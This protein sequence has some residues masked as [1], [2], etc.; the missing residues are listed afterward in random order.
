METTKKN[1]NIPG[2]KIQK[3]RGTGSVS[4]LYA[5]LPDWAQTVARD[6]MQIDIEGM[7]LVLRDSNT[8]SKVLRGV[9]KQKQNV[10]NELGKRS[11]THPDKKESDSASDA[12]SRSA[13]PR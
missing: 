4:K 11:E 1:S 7:K 12:S 10:R 6:A 2:K 9:I 3:P 5:K 13:S 8:L